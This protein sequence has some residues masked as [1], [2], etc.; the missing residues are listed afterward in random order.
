MYNVVLRKID[1]FS[2]VTLFWNNFGTKDVFE[3]WYSRKKTQ[4]E[5]VK[6]GVSEEEAIRACLQPPANEIIRASFR[7]QLKRMRFKINRK[8]RQSRRPRTKQ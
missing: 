5:I 7:N 4:C 1:G 2:P 3:K 8:L 6:A